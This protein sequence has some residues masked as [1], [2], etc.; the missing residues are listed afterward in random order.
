MT[1]IRTEQRTFGKKTKKMV[2]EK[3][4]EAKRY[5]KTYHGNYVIKNSN[6]ETIATWH[7]PNN[8]NQNGLLVIY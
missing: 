4:K 3:V 6:N 7:K 8:Y 5:I 1:Q 2:I